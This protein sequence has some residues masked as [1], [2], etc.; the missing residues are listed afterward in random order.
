MRL[1]KE[2]TWPDVDEIEDKDWETLKEFLEDLNNVLQD[3]HKDIHSDLRELEK[4]ITD[5]EALP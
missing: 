5:L 4:R 3:L 2:L 1:P